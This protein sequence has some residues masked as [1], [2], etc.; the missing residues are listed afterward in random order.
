MVKRPARAAPRAAARGGAAPTA[1][2]APV[3]G[4]SGA[5][6]PAWGHFVMGDSKAMSVVSTLTCSLVPLGLGLGGAGGAVF[7]V[8]CGLSSLA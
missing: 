8:A 5:G 1:P 4:D 7:G 3:A 2:A 6:H